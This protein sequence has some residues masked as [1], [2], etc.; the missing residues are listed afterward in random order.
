[1]TATIAVAADE[2]VERIGEAKSVF[3]EI[4]A[5]PDKG[6]PTSLL[7]KAH[8]IAIV[9]AVKRAGLVVGGQYGKGVATCRAPS[10]KGWTG[11]S[12]VRIEGGSF[13][14]QIGA[15]E[16][17]VIMMVMNEKGAEKLMKSEFTLGGEGAA[18]AGP[19]GRSATAE[20][21]AYLRAEILS[22]SR[23]RGL[24]AGAVLKG[25]TLRSDDKDNETIYGKAVKHE[26]ILRG[27]VAATSSATALLNTLTKYSVSEEKPKP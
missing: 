6:I 13:G 4:M 25:A 2:A 11:L 23:S 18:M 20:T 14:L 3:E 22:Y 7:E 10:G 21:D 8:C 27:R 1:M 12:T 17:D 15:G 16:T 24:F 26:D 5:A 19:V 9:P